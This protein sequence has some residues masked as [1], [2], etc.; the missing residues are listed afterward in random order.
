MPTTKQNKPKRTG[1]WL[2]GQQR[3]VRRRKAASQRNA[4]RRHA[5]KTSGAPRGLPGWND[6]SGANEKKRKVRTPAYLERVST[7][8]FALLVMLLA[9]AFTAYVGHVHAT[10]AL[11]AELQQARKENLRLHLKH[12]RLQGNYDRATGPSVVYDRARALGLEEDIT[13]GP[14]IVLED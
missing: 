8:R 5:A 4:V 9:A 7:I 12:D 3:M 6:L 10:Q 1:R 13:Y 11:F 2:L 14:T